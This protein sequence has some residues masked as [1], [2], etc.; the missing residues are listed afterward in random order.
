MDSCVLCETL[1]DGLYARPQKID[2]TTSSMQ[3]PPVVMPQF[4]GSLEPAVWRY[5]FAAVDVTNW[6]FI[7]SECWSQMRVGVKFSLKKGPEL[8][9]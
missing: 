9:T 3:G 8:V 4:K 5:D 2:I 6:A 1:F 7:V